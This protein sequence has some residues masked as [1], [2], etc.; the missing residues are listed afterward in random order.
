MTV[1]DLLKKYRET[2]GKDVDFT[3]SPTGI[4]QED[5]IPCLELM[6]A[7]NLSLLQAYNVL[8]RNRR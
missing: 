8:K 5:I 3:I 6:I 4:T 7:D 2:W 1:E